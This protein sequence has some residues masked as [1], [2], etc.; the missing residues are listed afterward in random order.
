MGFLV[1]SA[2]KN[3]P[4]NAGD[5][6]DAGSIPESGRYPGE[7]NGNPLQCSCLEN[8]M[9]GRAWW[10]T[11][12][13][14]AK[15][16]TRLSDFTFTFTEGREVVASPRTFCFPRGE[17]SPLSPD[18]P[19]PRPAG[20]LP[21]CPQAVTVQGCLSAGPRRPGRSC[22]GCV[23]WCLPWSRALVTVLSPGWGPRRP[24]ACG[25][26]WGHGA[27]WSASGRGWGLGRWRA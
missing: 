3:L 23:S 2:V 27:W 12:R 5:L 25:Q 1:A 9:D 22:Q 16:Q 6:R 18:G 21:G 15:S 7:G 20:G 17:E 24:R 8:P 4:A 19:R 13:G 14:V 10:A 26:A 11:V